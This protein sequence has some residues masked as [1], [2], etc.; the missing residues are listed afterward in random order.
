MQ[1]TLSWHEIAL[2]LALA[3]AAGA[4]IGLN[5]SERGRTA[6]LR[7]T[8]LVCLAACLAMVQAN[9]LLGTAG[10][11]PDSFIVLDLMRLPLGILSGMGFIGAGAILRK[12]NL[13]LGVTTAATL[14]FVTVIGLCFGG[15]Q[16]KL[17]IV[18][19]LLGIFVLW[20]LHWLEESLP[21]DRQGLLALTL[22]AGG[23]TEEDIRNRLLAEHCQI[24][25][26]A[27]SYEDNAQRR[28]IRFQVRWRTHSGDARTPHFVEELAHHS[29]VLALDWKL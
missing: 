2:R 8:I 19:S 4:L 17:G 25:S 24:I 7:T 1:L 29:G 3:F 21:V 23:P 15:G 5:R 12:G 10:K 6:G 20:V 28:G 27:R 18:G 13:L 22:Q 16:L 14:W 9:L 26:T 11:R